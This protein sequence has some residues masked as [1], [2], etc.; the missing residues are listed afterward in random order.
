MKLLWLVIP[1]VLIMPFLISPSP[2]AGAPPSEEIPWD[3]VL[4]AETVYVE[5]SDPIVTRYW[6]YYICRDKY[7]AEVLGFEVRKDIRQL[8]RDLEQVKAAIR[9]RKAK[10]P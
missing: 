8:K 2:Q 3:S 9:A 6:I 4:C 5:G 10:D 7:E 1:A